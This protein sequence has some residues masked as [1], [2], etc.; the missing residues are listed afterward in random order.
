MKYFITADGQYHVAID[1][2]LDDPSAVEVPERP[3]EAHVW[4][5]DTWSSV[6]TQEDPLD[7]PLL[8]WQFQAMIDLLG[9]RTAIEQ[10]IAALPTVAEQA[11]ATA[12]LTHSSRFRRDDPLVSGLSAAVGMTPAE[13]D[14]AWLQ[15][16]DLA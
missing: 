15:A 14:A 2:D 6:Q 13:L 4:Q 5:D 7:Y 1:G 10:A 9:K 12:K 8:R 11:V 16:K 3:S